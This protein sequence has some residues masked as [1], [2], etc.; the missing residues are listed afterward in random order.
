M[1]PLTP[2][3]P[4]VIIMVGIPGSG[5]STFAE[6]FAETFQAPIIN[7]SKLKNE[8]GLSEEAVLTLRNHF[9]NEYIKTHRTILLDGGMNRKADRADVMRRLV[10]AGYHPLV[11]WVQ[12]DAN[13]ARRRAT[14]DYPNGSNLS[15]D[16]FDVELKKFQAPAATE[17]PIV[18]SGK[19]TYAT[20]LKIVLK[21]LASNANRPKNLPESPDRPRARGVVLR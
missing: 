2:A 3:S 19:H 7:H 20:Q 13:E 1:K 16:S 15:T 12:T 17:K 14:K 4:H 9:L 18:M 6:H 5:K 10:K 21:Q 11:V 8:F